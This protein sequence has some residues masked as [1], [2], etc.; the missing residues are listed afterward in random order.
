MSLVN[1]LHFDS[2]IIP[3]LLTLDG[4]APS[5]IVISNTVQ[6]TGTSSLRMSAYNGNFHFTT[7]LTI[8]GFVNEFFLQ[9]AYYFLVPDTDSRVFK[10]VSPAGTI[11][12]GLR[13]NVT[14]WML[15]VYTGNFA[16]LVATSATSLS[17]LTWCMIELHVKIDNAGIIEL[18]INSSLSDGAS[19]SGDTQ[20]DTNT[21][22][23]TL[24][25]GNVWRANYDT[26]SYLD[27]IIVNDVSGSYNNSW[28]NGGKVY[29]AALTGDGGINQWSPSPA[30]LT[31]YT[32]VDEVPPSAVD[33]IRAST[34]NL[35]DIF[36][37]ANLPA[38]AGTIKAVIPEVF[39]FKAS[40]DEPT[41]LGIGIDVG[42]GVEYSGDKTL[43]INQS[44]INDIWEQRPGGGNF[45]S[46]D[47]NA[48]Q[49]YLK[50]LP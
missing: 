49:L 17:A 38:G 43:S 15:E 21:M 16:T 35:V 48:L 28:P 5:N 41:K 20:P 23:S 34:T 26:Y 47:V 7:S 6:R 36:S 45:S 44:L 11:L 29:Y 8:P 33:Y 40:V 50:S 22:V 39:A 32:A 4:G 46:A 24:V 13:L 27:D 19:F 1:A 42:S 3:P 2:G 31:H 12:G 10:W 14:T 37:V 9:Y 25:W 30:G 18:R